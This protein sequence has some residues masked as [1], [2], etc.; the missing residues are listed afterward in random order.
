LVGGLRFLHEGDAPVGR[1]SLL[2]T[3]NL[4][5]DFDAGKFIMSRAVQRAYDS[6]S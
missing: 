5:A 6:R 4:D 2:N 1:R 3:N